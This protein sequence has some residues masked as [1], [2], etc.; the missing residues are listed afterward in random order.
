MPYA[1]KRMNPVL[2]AVMHDWVAGAARRVPSPLEDGFVPTAGHPHPLPTAITMAGEAGGQL[3]TFL[4]AR[5]LGHWDIYC[6][7]TGDLHDADR[8][9]AELGDADASWHPHP[10]GRN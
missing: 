1:V 4:S 3:R 7:N 6:H 9:L 8:H 10:P 5:G 2:A